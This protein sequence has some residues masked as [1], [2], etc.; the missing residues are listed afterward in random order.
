MSQQC[1]N[2]VATLCC[3]KSRRRESSRVTHITLTE[4]INPFPSSLLQKPVLLFKTVTLSYTSCWLCPML[5]AVK[6]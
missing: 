2:N 5:L 4:Q 3:A 1:R 6:K